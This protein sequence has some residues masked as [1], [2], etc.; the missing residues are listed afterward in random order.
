MLEQSTLD[1][2]DSMERTH[3]K[4]VVEEL[5][6]MGSTYSGAVCEG[7]FPM[8]ETTHWSMGKV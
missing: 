4:F 8:G 2:P 6:Y 3:T 1:G 5:Q 7:L